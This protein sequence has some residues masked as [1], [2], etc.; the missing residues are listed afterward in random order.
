[1]DRHEIKTLIN[2]YLR[3]NGADY[4]AVFGSFARQDDHLGSDIDI[5]VSF[6]KPVGLLS[7]VQM[8]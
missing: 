6:A 3:K 2:E 1:M 8:E 4:V 5:L 7:L